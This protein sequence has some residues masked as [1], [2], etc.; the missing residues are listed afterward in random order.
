MLS[1][2]EARKL[3]K[4]HTWGELADV[5]LA[6][7][8][9]RKTS[10]AVGWFRQGPRGGRRPLY[11]VRLGIVGGCA[12]GGCCTFEDAE[13]ALACFERNAV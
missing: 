2:Q 7:S 6:E 13:K 5:Y 1:F 4:R 12:L 8:L 11:A 3:A 10:L 9:D